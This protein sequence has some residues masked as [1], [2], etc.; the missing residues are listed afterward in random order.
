MPRRVVITG[1]GAVTPLGL[2]VSD[3][4]SAILA[5]RSG[6]G[7]I[8][9]FDTTGWNMRLGCELKDFDPGQFMD[10]KEARRRDRFEQ[11]AVAAA[12]QALVDSG[13]QVTDANAERV[14]SLIST[15][16]GGAQAIQDATQVM[17]ASGP[18]KVSPFMIPMTM[19]NGASGL[20]AIDFGLRGPAFS[21]SSA[22]AA[23]ADSLGIA[24]ELIR[25]G[26][27][28]AALAGGSE[29]SIVAVG[30]AGFDRV[31]AL[32]RRNDDWSMTPQ[33]F[34]R[35]RDGLV[36]GEGAAVVMLE[37]LEQARRR[38][39]HIYAELAG[40]GST[41]DAFHIT[42][43]DENGTGAV[44]AMRQA[45]E[46]A[47]L[48]VGDVDYISAHG[49]ATQLNDS[50]E[51]RAVKKLF[52]AQA[53]HV[54]M[55]STKSMTGHMIAATGALEAIFCA[56]AIRDGV[57][58]PTIHYQTPDPECDLDYVP[59]TAREKTVNLCLSN[60][61]G[62]GGHNAVLAIRRFEA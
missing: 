9:L 38:G 11:M 4:W 27:I 32:S 42:A 16:V 19:V 17:F 6:V 18:R 61:F 29:A 7:P 10:P 37:E 57:L 36:A 46:Q 41:N 53:Y 51:T 26:R 13:F 31:G 50:T 24:A 2:N 60:A 3:T 56:L 28:D 22:C 35:N 40:Y 8:T 52:G 25:A 30:L 12:K 5:G 55:S 59:N 44:A 20:V 48:N 45:L 62:F 47:R 15:G 58:P 49:T 34:D 14:G 23:G 33:P 21:V 54:P 43:P 39:A 1:V